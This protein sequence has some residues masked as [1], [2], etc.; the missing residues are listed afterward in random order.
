M[1]VEATRETNLSYWPHQ[2]TKDNILNSS[3]Y[4][5]QWDI[6]AM[7]THCSVHRHQK[8]IE[9][10]ANHIFRADSPEGVTAERP[11][12]LDLCTVNNVRP[13]NSWRRKAKDG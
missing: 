6:F 4:C 9:P 12:K 13:D 5:P 8:L 2:H 7:N 1:D 3:E 11:Q 10:Q